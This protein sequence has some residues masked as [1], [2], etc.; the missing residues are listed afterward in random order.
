M[1][2]SSPSPSIPAK[3]GIQ[4]KGLDRREVAVPAVAEDLVFAFWTPA[5]AGVRGGL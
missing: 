2:R 4:L 1:D 3:A 5:F